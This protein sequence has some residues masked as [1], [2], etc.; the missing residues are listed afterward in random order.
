MNVKVL[1]LI[2][3]LNETRYLVQ[4]ESCECKCGLSKSA[5]NSKQKWNHDERRY[6]R[7]ELDDCV[8]CER[9]DMR[10][11]SKSDCKCDKTCKLDEYLDIKI[12]Y[13]KNV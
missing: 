2:S 3:V 4:H 12:V 11:H 9:G 7:K 13:A 8:S 10:N 5:C 6:E 1:N